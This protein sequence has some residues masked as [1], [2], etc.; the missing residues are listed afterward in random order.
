[1][2]GLDVMGNIERYGI[3]GKAAGEAVLEHGRDGARLRPAA[4]AFLLSR[5]ARAVVDALDDHYR[6]AVSERDALRALID[7]VR[8]MI[9]DPDVLNAIDEV[10]PRPSQGGQ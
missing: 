4:D 8:F 3:A 9:E 6:G 10:Y 7:E 5:I 2:G 1:M